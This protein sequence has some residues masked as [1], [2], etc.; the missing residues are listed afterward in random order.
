MGDGWVGD[1]LLGLRRGMDRFG[2]CESPVG[3]ARQALRGHHRESGFCRCDGDHPLA[4][5][6]QWKGMKRWREPGMDG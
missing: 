2:P 5:L 4:H 3:E 6:S 1:G